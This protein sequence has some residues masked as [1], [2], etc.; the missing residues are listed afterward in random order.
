MPVCR[1]RTVSVAIETFG[2]L[3]ETAI[4]FLRDLGRHITNMTAERREQSSC[5]S[6]SVVPFSE[7]NAACVLGTAA[8]NDSVGLDDMLGLL[9]NIYSIGLSVI[10]L[11]NSLWLL[12]H[13]DNHDMIC[14]HSLAS[15]LTRCMAFN[16]A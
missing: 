9:V 2:A 5:Y 16:M 10:A 12:C 3:G 11:N 6:A 8:D 7:G 4:D 14:H 15:S 1:Q 13:D